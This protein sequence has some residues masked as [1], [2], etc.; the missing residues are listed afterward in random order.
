M[1]N[2][3]HVR[4]HERI[5]YLGGVRL[6]NPDSKHFAIVPKNVAEWRDRWELLGIF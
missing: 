6:R 1:L 3:I 5:A 4:Y 2:H